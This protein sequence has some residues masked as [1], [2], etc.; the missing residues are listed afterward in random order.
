MAK[1]LS[2]YGQKLLDPR[3]QKMRLQVMEREIFTCQYCGDKESTLH[4]HH[5][6]Y[7]KSRNPWDV[8]IR[9]LECLCEKCHSIYH[10]KNLTV[11]EDQLIDF[12][13]TLAVIYNNTEGD[14]G[15]FK[16]AMQHINELI[17]NQKSNG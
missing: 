1:I 11:L 3:W 13:R 9:A 16:K 8:D 14:N 4:I 10:L 7:A 12:L 15:Y 2:T 5:L 17:L 6:Y